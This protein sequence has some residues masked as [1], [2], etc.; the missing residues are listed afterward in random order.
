MIP[1]SG[2]SDR[3]RKNPGKGTRNNF[4]V[5]LKKELP[6]SAGWRVNV[7]ELVLMTCTYGECTY[8]EL[9]MTT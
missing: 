2:E 3:G 9:L 4:P 5:L 8:G 6:I 1:L 7:G